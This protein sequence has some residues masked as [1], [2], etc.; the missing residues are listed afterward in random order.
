MNLGGD[1]NARLGF[2]ANETSHVSIKPS[3]LHTR[4]TPA[5]GDRLV[6]LSTLVQKKKLF[7]FSAHE[8][9]IAGGVDGAVFGHC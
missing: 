4:F 7:D 2:A 3:F 9:T 6:P 1:G 8:I 5:T